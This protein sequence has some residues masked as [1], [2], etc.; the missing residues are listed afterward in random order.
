MEKVEERTVKQSAKIR[1][2]MSYLN[3]FYGSSKKANKWLEVPNPLLGN[4]SPKDMI[5]VG[6]LDKLIKFV[7]T[8]LAE[9][10]SN[11]RI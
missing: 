3:G 11:G 8:E 4:V 7:E 6:R 5:R 10:Q 1:L 2:L 9:N